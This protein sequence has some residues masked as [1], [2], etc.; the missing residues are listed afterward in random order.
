VTEPIRILAV[1]RDGDEGLIV[2]FFDETTAAYV[3]LGRRVNGRSA[4]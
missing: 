1:E 3:S 2:T 4:A